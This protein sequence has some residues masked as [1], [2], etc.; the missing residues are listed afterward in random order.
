MLCSISL[1]L[2]LP[3][4]ASLTV[5][6]ELVHYVSRFP[7]KLHPPKVRNVFP[8]LGLLQLRNEIANSYDAEKIWPLLGF[9]GDVFANSCSTDSAQ[10]SESRIESRPCLGFETT[11]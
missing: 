4:T 6:V 3:D 1:L 2:V 5:D 11:N 9:P 7:S 10:T 8:T